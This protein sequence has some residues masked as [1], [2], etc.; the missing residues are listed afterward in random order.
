MGILY[1]RGWRK[2]SLGEPMWM[3]NMPFIMDL[4]DDRSIKE[5]ELEGI[6]EFFEEGDPGES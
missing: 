5:L 2:L 4:D 6:E 1:Y 3:D